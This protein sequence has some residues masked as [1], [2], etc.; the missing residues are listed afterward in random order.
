MI[1]MLQTRIKNGQ[2][3]IIGCQVGETFSLNDIFEYSIFIS[4]VMAKVSAASIHGQCLMFTHRFVQFTI[5]PDV[6][7]Y[8]FKDG[9]V[10]DV[11]WQDKTITGTEQQK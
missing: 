4:T 6:W 5:Q 7:E 3:A 1:L 8:T 11:E 9:K 2:T 10:N